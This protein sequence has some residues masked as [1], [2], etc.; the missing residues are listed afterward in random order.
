LANEV[1][2]KEDAIHRLMSM[3][4]SRV[5]EKYMNIPRFI[6][7]LTGLSIMLLLAS[8]AKQESSPHVS[9][10]EPE[11]AVTVE[12]TD[13]DIENIVRRSYQYVAMYN[14]NN[15]FALAAGGWNTCDANTQLKDHTMKDVARPNNDTL[16]I[17]CMLDLRKDPVILDIPAFD[18]KYASLMVTGY[19]HYVNVPVS[20]TLWD[21]KTREQVLFY[22]AQTDDYDGHPVEGVDRS[23]EMTGDFVSAV[24]RIMPHA[25]DKSRYDRIVGQMQ[26]VKP[27]TLSEFQGKPARPIN[28]VQFPDV[29]K[30]D[31]DVYENNFLEVMQFVLNHSIFEPDD[32]VDQAFLACLKPLGIEPGKTFDKTKAV[33]ID[34]NDSETLQK[35][36]KR[37]NS[38]APWTRL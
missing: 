12:L 14:V 22:T 19:D 11:G 30:S 15:K 13:E 9:S 3:D 28:D 38:P 20:V 31:L 21:F 34:G 25:S 36:F 17:G 1:L 10:V 24:F 33:N 4:R 23:F 29:G 27:V 5:N 8:C 16:Y 18:S 35:R 6:T 32:E 2:W 26:S 7:T 37:S